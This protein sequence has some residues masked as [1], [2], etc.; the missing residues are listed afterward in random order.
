MYPV[1]LQ[2]SVCKHAFPTRVEKS[3]DPDQMALKG[4]N[5]GAVGQGLR[6]IHFSVFGT[7]CRPNK[8]SPVEH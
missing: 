2:H 7:E 8:F 4:I 3:V 5:L 1:N 6:V